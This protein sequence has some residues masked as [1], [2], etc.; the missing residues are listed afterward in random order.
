MSNPIHENILSRIVE[1]PD[2]IKNSNIL[3]NSS[4][5]KGQICDALKVIEIG[6]SIKFTC[7]E[8][9]KEF[10]KCWK[11]T[12]YTYLKTNGINKPKV[13][14]VKDVVYIFSRSRI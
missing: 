11:H 10:G 8:L 12:L 5:L 2:Y 13:Q 4:I 1:T 3:R 7:I 14:I 6:K 9:E